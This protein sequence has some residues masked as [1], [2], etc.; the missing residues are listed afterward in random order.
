[1]SY[2]TLDEAFG[3]TY[4]NQQNKFNSTS[5]INNQLDSCVKKG[6]IRRKKINCNEKKK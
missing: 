1:M 4:L 2:C 3:N 5:N 6:K